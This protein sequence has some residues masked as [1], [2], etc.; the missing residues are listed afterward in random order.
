MSEKSSL[1]ENVDHSY[2]ICEVLEVL[3]ASLGHF[4]RLYQ[5]SRRW[6][7]RYGLINNFLEHMSIMINA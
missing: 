1:V 5:K 4:N 6:K 7:S 2:L 3:D